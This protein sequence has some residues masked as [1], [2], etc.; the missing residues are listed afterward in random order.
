M[1]DNMESFREQ[2]RERGY[3]LTTQRQAILDV[4]Q[5]HEGEH[6]TP[7]EI[8]ELVKSRFPEIGLATVYRTLILL[9]SMELAN[10]LDLEDGFSRY[11]INKNREDHRHHHLICT[12]CGSVDEV[13]EDLLE[14]LEE[15]ILKKNGFI[16][17]DHRVKFY[18]FCKKCRKDASEL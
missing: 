17:K 6:L 9:N 16:V 4:L 10:R 13:E 2:L 18:G 15:Q 14:S 3:K 7:E 1:P 11:E 5:E 12:Q 8:Y